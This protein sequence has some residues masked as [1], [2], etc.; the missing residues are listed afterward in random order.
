[1]S[2]IVV[3]QNNRTGEVSL[4]QG[5]DHHSVA[6]RNG[7]SLADYIHA[8]YG[9]IRQA[10]A[11]NV[12]LIGGGGGTLATMLD[13]VGVRVTMV[14]INP[15]AF[16][17]A[18]QYFHLP[19]AVACHVGDGAAFLRRTATRFDAIALDAYSGGEVPPQFLKPNFFA[20][21]RS[22][23]TRGGILLANVIAANDADRFADRVAELMLTAWREV[24][25]LDC[26]GYDD[27]N[28]VVIGGAVTRLTPPRLTMVPERSV[29]VIA[30]ALAEMEFRPLR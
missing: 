8:M 21:A 22:R 6:D 24:R 2:K 28:V 12:L 3:E 14:D 16:E 18:R 1:M 11:Q 13:R 30:R 4:W 7:V 23:L 15:A 10:G 19:D 5:T 29:R 17:I 9:L 27:R 25:I 20:L 26:D